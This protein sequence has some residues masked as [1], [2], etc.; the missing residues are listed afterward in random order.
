M[1]EPSDG[2]QYG[3]NGPTLK[4]LCAAWNVGNAAPPADLDP[5]I[6]RGGRAPKAEGGGC[7]DVVAVGVQECDYKAADDAADDSAAVGGGADLG[8]LHHFLRSVQAHLGA[9]AYVTV[10]TAELM[11]MRL[12]VLL[13][14]AH[15]GGLDVRSVETAKS[16][17]GIAHTIGN[18]GG[19]TCAFWLYGT[20]L[21]F[22]SCHLAAHE[23]EKFMLRRNADVAEVMAEALVGDKKLD[24]ESQFHHSFLMGDLNYRVNLGIAEG[25]RRPVDSKE[26]H[27]A[28][29]AE[30]LALVEARDWAALRG[31]DELQDQMRK[32][33]VLWGWQDLPP[34]FR[35]TFKVERESVRERFHEKRTPSYCDRILYRSLP[36]YEGR[37][38]PTLFDSCP[39]LVT[40]DHKPVRAVFSVD[41]CAPIRISHDALTCPEIRVTDLSCTPAAA[42]AA[43][44]PE[45]GSADAREQLWALPGKALRGAFSRFKAGDPYIKFCSDP[46]QLLRHAKSNRRS[47]ATKTLLATGSPAWRDEQVPQMLLG[48][49]SRADLARAHLILAEMDFDPTSGD[50]PLGYAVLPLRDFLHRAGPVAFECEMACHGRGPVGTVRGKAQVL[51]PKDGRRPPGSKVEDLLFDELHPDARGV[52]VLPGRCDSATESDDD[53]ETSALVQHVR[54]LVLSRRQP[55]LKALMTLCLP[56]S[57]LNGAIPDAIGRLVCLK[58][59]DLGYNALEGRVPP[60]VGELARLRVLDLRS[61]RLSGPLPAALG[62]CSALQYLDVSGNALVS[63]VLPAE[64]AQLQRLEAADFTGCSFSDAASM[65]R[66]FPRACRVFGLARRA[67]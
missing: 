31:C 59:L 58:A 65:L 51:W 10:A 50:D 20:S 7:Y 25:G 4:V 28:H 9:D 8:R 54:R 26:Q 56:R 29:R 60:S 44:A 32:G 23:K 30:A 40:S 15:E 3:W 48:S 19:L 47:P 61:N 45:P 66:M 57:G 27:A 39:T 14:R 67:Q 1:V 43:A 62:R 35:P 42:A 21:C 33:K 53:S 22:T 49:T 2:S 46:P 63:G 37:C 55:H 17:T 11:E 24:I 18:K 16:A 36:V 34:S 12:I 5:W 6:P 38:R 41:T 13:H 64:L 52:D